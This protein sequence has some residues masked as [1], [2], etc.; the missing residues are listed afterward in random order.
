[1]KKKIVLALA[2]SAFVNVSFAADWLEHMRNVNLMDSSRIYDIDEIIVISQP[3]E[4]F[5]L[6]QQPV[7]SSMFSRQEMQSLN[8]RDLR[9]LSAYVPSFGMPNY[10]SR[11]TSSMYI[12]GIGSRINSP[13]VGIYV[14]G[15]P[16]MSK[17][18]FNFHTYGLERVDIL[19]GPQ[20]T[21]YGQNTEG[22]IVRMYSLNPMTYQG[23]DIDLG[24]GSHGYR[25]VEIS[26]YQKMND[27]FAFSLGGFYNGQNGFFRN[28]G[29]GER[30]DKYDEAGGKFRFVFRPTQ[31]LNINYTADYQYVRQNG[32][33][34]GIFDQ[35][36]GVTAAPETDRQG[37]Y[38]RNIFNTALSF[39][40]NGRFFDFNSTTSCQYLKDYMLMDI[41]YLPV[42]YMHMEERQLQNALT[43]EFAFKS[44]HSSFWHW[45][46]GAFASQQWLRTDA[47]VYFGNDMD[48]FL[49]QTITNA[50]YNA[51]VN[52][53]A[54]RFLAQGMSAERAAQMAAA[55]IERAGGVS[56]NVDLATVPGLFHTPQFN[57]GLYHESN[58]D[59]TDRLTA[60]LGLRY[61]FSRVGIDYQT[62]AMMTS[63]AK[64]MGTP[65]TVVLTSK[66]NDKTHDT[67]NQLLPKFGLKY[68]VDHQGSNVYATVS[69]GYRA[70]GY[71]IQMFSDILQAELN[72][73]SSQRSDYDIPHTE[74]DYDNIRR[75]ISYRPEESW[76]YE[77][78]TH[79]NLFSSQL[80]LDLSAFYVQVHN[81]QLS[82]MAG[83][84]GF[85][86]M[87]VNAGKSYSCG[88]EASLRG[89]AFNN[90]LD[91]NLNYSY[92]HAVF[93]EYVDSM[94]V[95]EALQAVDYKDKRVPFVPQHM[96]S[97]GVDYRF[98]LSSAVLKSVVI[99]SNFSGQGKTFWDESNTV[100]QKF[101]AVVGAH[102]DFNFPRVSVSLW[103]RNLTDTKYNSFAV[104]S[105]A[106][107]T[108][109]TFAQRGNPFQ[110]GVDARLH[111]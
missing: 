62:S 27:R 106:T 63:A 11:Y 2:L 85:G 22:G 70:G 17:S 80:H 28:K 100:S 52:S 42:D 47:P 55:T 51:M 31:W 25:N 99:G 73:N 33:P 53:M 72:R 34:Y 30:A 78:G 60:T 14:D 3:K 19:R 61:D 66:L 111:F 56:M 13:A 76:N 8:V 89:R 24:G 108:A 110:F 6:R 82:V 97:G 40:Y 45:T 9:E 104:Q 41:D 102:A 109:Y 77:V 75:T 79:L 32:F 37:N 48:A 83:R 91:W 10:G 64:V 87:M 68:V 39:D 16:L 93:K 7:S 90:R 103:G 5:R 15:M 26:H 74:Q 105:S 1:M 50:M 12:R 94:T 49:G 20:G 59:L 54:Q 67:F 96:L 69:K 81:Q 44:N 38:R 21:L 29:T 23:T 86:R 57:L 58:F 35:T 95:G 107:G 101:Y 88:V 92:T 84:Y 46:F 4:Q 18:A 65:A 71:N 36:T 43:Q 98:D